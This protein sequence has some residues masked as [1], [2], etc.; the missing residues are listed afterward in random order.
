MKALVTGGWGFIGSHL[1]DRLRK[2]GHDVIIVDNKAPAK[3]RD[4]AIYRCDI[5]DTSWLNDIMFTEKPDTVFHLAA[6]ASVRDSFVRPYEYY[7]NNV[8]GTVSLFESLSASVENFVFASSG[9]T[10]Y[11]KPLVFPVG[12]LS[13]LN[14]IDPYGATKVAGEHY[15]EIQSAKREI[16]WKNLRYP[17]VYGPR[18][19][20]YGE[21]GV[22][23]IFCQDVIDYLTPVINGDGE[24]VRDF[25]HV[26]DVVDATIKSLDITPGSYNVGSEC[27]TSINQIASHIAVASGRDVEFVHGPPKYGEARKII[28][29]KD[30][31]YNVTDVSEGVKETYRWFKEKSR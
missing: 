23:A 3:Q 20:P 18:Q 26:N 21:S 27:G 2:L 4:N 28:L 16:R 24:N 1:A 11:G 19:D 17:N 15:V 13:R 6:L 5:R 9:G 14:P 25:L 12:R 7:S 29:S 8:L 10:V 31:E 22:V 30:F